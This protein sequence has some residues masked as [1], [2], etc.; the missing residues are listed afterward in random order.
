MGFTPST[1]AAGQQLTVYFSISRIPYL[2]RLYLN[3]CGVGS[4]VMHSLS[5]NIRYKDV[6][7]FAL[8][9]A[10]FFTTS[11]DPKVIAAQE[12][13]GKIFRPGIVPSFFLWMFTNLANIC[14]VTYND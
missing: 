13:M 12:S 8:A 10:I 3:R 2:F 14:L 5:K 7:R 1:A 11:N 4:R 9:L 6:K